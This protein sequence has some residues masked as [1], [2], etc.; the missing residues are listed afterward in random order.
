MKKVIKL[1]VLIFLGLILIG[2]CSLWVLAKSHNNSV[3]DELVNVINEEFDGK[4]SFGDLRF[5]YLSNFPN[6]RIEL[7]DVTFINSNAGESH[8]ERINVVLRLGSLFR[9]TLQIKKLSVENG[10]FSNEID[11]LGRR[12][13]LFGENTDS[14]SKNGRKLLLKSGDIEVENTQLFF[15]NQYKKNRMYIMVKSGR[16]ELSSTDTTL[17]LQGK[18]DA[19]LDS[20]ISKRTTLIKNQAARVENAA[21]QIHRI[22]GV[23]ELLDGEI[24]ANDLKLTPSLKLIPEDDGNIID[25]HILGDGNLDA[26]VDLFEVHVGSN[27]KQLNPNADL[28]ISYNQEGF[29]NP[30]KRPYFH[31]D[32]K[33]KD[34]RISSDKLRYPLSKVTLEGNYNNGSSHSP[35]TAAIKVDTLNAEI[36]NSYIRGRFTM[37]NLSDPIIDA[38]LVSQIDLGH[39]LPDSNKYELEGMVDLD[40]YT[41]GKISE[42][43]QLDFNKKEAAKG[44]ITFNNVRMRAPKS[45][46]AVSFKNGRIVLKNHF[47][48]LNTE[49]NL[50][51]ASV[52][53]LKGEFNNLDEYLLGKTKALSGKLWVDFDM[54]DMQRLPILNEK[55]N[56]SGKHKQ[57]KLPAF[58]FD[59]F[60][61][62]NVLK[63]KYGVLNN[64]KLASAYRSSEVT[65]N[66]FAFNYQ[67]GKVSGSGKAILHRT[68]IASIKAEL[69]ANFK[70]LNFALPKKDSLSKK[71]KQKKFSLPSNLDA[72]VD[73]KIDKGILFD[74]PVENFDL[75]LNAKGERLEVDQ[76]R[77]KTKEGT[78]NFKGN[79][80]FREGEILQL[81]GSG[82]IALNKLVLDNYLL[83]NKI[84]DA[85]STR[86]V[87]GF[88]NL[89]KELDINLM[90]SANDV[91]YKDQFVKN[92]KTEFLVQ[93]ETLLVEY[94]KG[95]LAIGSFDLALKAN[96]IR[97]PDISY[98]ADLKMNLD[99]VNLNTLLKSE[100]F[101][102]PDK[103]ERYKEEDNGIVDF[104]FPTNWKVDLS[105]TA[106]SVKYKNAV[107]NNLDLAANYGNTKLELNRLKFNFGRGEVI[108]RGFLK[109]ENKASFPAYIFC[110]SNELDLSEVLLAFNNFKQ[111]EITYKNTDGKI[112]WESDL[113]FNLIESF[114]T[115][116]DSDLWKFKFRVHDAEFRDVKVIEETLSFIGHKAKDDFLV[117]EL[118]IVG[119]LDGQ[120]FLFKDVFINNNIVNMDVYGKINMRD[121]ILDLGVEASLSDLLF[122][123][124]KKRV[125]QTQEGEVP[126][127]GDLKIFLNV[128]GPKENRKV[129]TFS[130]KK[131]NRHREE[132][133]SQIEN[134][135]NRIQNQNS[136]IK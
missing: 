8:F 96:K 82:E 11:S 89:P 129:K 40:L 51:Q 35:E 126:L 58:V 37:S 99:V 100:V 64:V 78:T 104:S 27:L 85:D 134:V 31:L 72:T 86:R 17:L 135:E 106:N 23:K 128:L 121:S 115:P 103:K 10:F 6:A 26:F 94:F 105:A 79:L 71:D 116:S 80:N 7:R 98:V 62:G 52:L 77:F 95:D 24:Y 132:L 97:S 101:G 125:V 29:V 55:K 21:F 74:I 91:R 66:S 45:N 119:Y 102:I 19:S 127:E 112:S 69:N 73:L 76:L 136:P 108:T 50:D 36:E 88:K 111:D 87:L 42:L 130:K 68:D 122:R 124:K 133:S 107:V 30:F 93:N 118:D 22:T 110:E 9:D 61:N 39:F 15:G 70:E 92:L 59:L 41:K 53:E 5:S 109:K 84:E 38:H 57:S 83:D 12:P 65:M 25:F 34:A 18:A 123:S 28:I 44:V 48:K 47:V 56:N 2:I 14:K 63:T 81:S 32:F 13:K 4:I 120:E 90:L 49:V 131:F 46:N 33:I 54:L 75:Q 43:K 113:H 60:V 117:K 20:L 67:K 1:I 114:D 16:F 3:H